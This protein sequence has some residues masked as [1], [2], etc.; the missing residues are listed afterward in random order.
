MVQRWPRRTWDS[1]TERAIYQAQKLAAF[2]GKDPGVIVVRSWSDLAAHSDYEGWRR[3]VDHPS[4]E[5]FAEEVKRLYQMTEEEYDA[6]AEAN[7][8]GPDFIQW[9]NCRDGICGSNSGYLHRGQA[10]HKVPHLAFILGTEGSHA[11]DGDLANID[12]LFD[13]GYRVM[14]LHHFFD[15][16]LGGSLH[17]TSGDGLS[18]FGRAAVERMRE[19][20][21]IIDV[22]HSSEQTVRDALAMGAGPFI[23]SHTGFDGHCSSPRNISDGLMA[24]IAEDGGLIGVGFWEDVTCDA[25]PAGIADAILYGAN[26]FGVDHIALGSDYDG[27]VTVE[28]DASELAAITQA[29]MDA[30]MPDD[31]IRKVM[32]GNTVRFFLENLPAE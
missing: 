6:Y 24:D 2:A 18:D 22:A 23:V 5:E 28:L 4:D 11:L 17:G 19:K 12:R 9:P 14:G 30:G 26:K 13:V 1:R 16:K 21:I 31:D 10:I 32:G 20:E 3:Q 15:N 7:M 27:T 8:K 29:L 25:S